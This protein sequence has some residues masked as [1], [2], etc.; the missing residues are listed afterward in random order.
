MAI[1]AETQPEIALAATRTGFG[2][3]NAEHFALKALTF[4]R[5]TF[6]TS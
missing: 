6:V 1:L 3:W 2:N 5:S 4:S